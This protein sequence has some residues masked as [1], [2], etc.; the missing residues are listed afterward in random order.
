MTFRIWPISPDLSASAAVR[1]ATSRE[2]WA[3][4]SIASTA[5]VTASW[6]SSAYRKVKA[7]CSTTSA[8]EAAI[9]SAM[10]ASCCSEAVD[11]V[12]APVCLRRRARL[13]LSGRLQLLRTLGDALA[14]IADA[15]D[16]HA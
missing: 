5:F 6:P 4:A 13:R 9:V 11:S 16:E 12:T 1:S 15:V 3:I 14:A 7:A 2:R 10:S 8:L